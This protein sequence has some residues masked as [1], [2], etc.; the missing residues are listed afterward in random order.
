MAAPALYRTLTQ[1]I[2][3]Q[4]RA[5]VL[6]GHLPVGTPLREK[7]LADRFG[8]SR[9]PIRDS[10]LQLTHEGLLVSK[11]NC[12]VM[13]GR[14]LCERIQ[15]L[16][17]TLRRQIET[18]ALGMLFQD[19]VDVLAALE[20]TCAQLRIACEAEDMPAVVQHDMAFHRC[21]VE[22]QGDEEMV[23]IWLPIVVRMML[24]Y[25]RHKEL[26]D[27]YH[28]HVA[29]VDAIRKGQVKKAIRALEKNIQ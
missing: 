19:N 25:T 28:E 16:V 12:G 1:Q 27:S 20:E 10:L 9:G 11:P 3:D 29:I 7:A 2:A 14:N 17:V 8:V 21:L 24:H 23:A 5:E 4:I 18:H 6:S 13:V 15:P 26:M 22:R